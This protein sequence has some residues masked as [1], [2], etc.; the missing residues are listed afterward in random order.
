MIKN[1]I[2]PKDDKMNAQMSVLE[3][4]K[5]F[6]QWFSD[7]K[8]RFS[9]SFVVAVTILVMVSLPKHFPTSVFPI[10]GGVLGTLGSSLVIFSFFVDKSM[11]MQPMPLVF[12]RAVADFFIG[13]RF[14]M[15]PL[16][17]YFICKDFHCTFYE[18]F[19]HE[20]R[21]AFASAWLE[22][23]ELASECWFFCVA[24]DTFFSICD[25]F[26][27]FKRRL[28][29]YHMFSWGLPLIFGLFT[30][31]FTYPSMYTELSPDGDYENTS[32]DAYIPETSRNSVGGF[33]Y[34]RTNHY[35]YNH[36]P[37]VNYNGDTVK[38]HTSYV[39]LNT[40]CWLR[41]YSTPC[42]NNAAN[43]RNHL[44]KYTFIFLYVPLLL[45]YGVAFLLIINTIKTLKRGISA[46]FLPRLR[47]MLINSLN[48]SVGF[49]YWFFLILCYTLTT[50]IA[51]DENIQDKAMASV[52]NKLLQFTI[53]SKGAGAF[54]VWSMMYNMK[55]AL[56]EKIDDS[57]DVN[58][59]L[60]KELLLYTSEGI[61][62]CAKKAAESQQDS[63]LGP[64]SSK[65]STSSKNS[66]S[67]K[68]GL[69]GK[70][71]SG[72]K[73]SNQDRGD[74][75]KICLYISHGVERTKEHN[76]DSNFA[77]EK[78][79]FWFFLK[80][81]LGFTKEINELQ[82]F[83]KR[84]AK[85]QENV[86]DTVRASF[87]LNDPYSAGRGSTGGIGS[88]S[89]KL[90]STV[91]METINEK[92]KNRT[93]SS[94]TKTTDN[95]DGRDSTLS[96]AQILEQSDTRA[97]NIRDT[98]VPTQVSLSSE[99]DTTSRDTQR[100]VIP[101]TRREGN[102][103]VYSDNEDNNRRS[104]LETVKVALDFEDAEPDQNRSC[105]DLL[106]SAVKTGID[107]LTMNTYDQDVEF[108]E[109]LPHE[110]RKI[111]L[112][113]G[114]TD[115]YYQ[116][117]FT[118]TVKERATEGGASGA[119]FF[120]SKDEICVAKAMSEEDFNALLSHAKEYVA[121]MID[122]E[123]SYIAKIYGCYQ[124]NIYRQKFFL[125]VMNNIFLN[126]L[127]HNN[128]DA[129]DIKGSWEARNAE[130]PKK[131]QRVPCKHCEQT[132]VYTKQKKK[133]RVANSL[134]SPGTK[135]WGGFGAT[136]SPFASLARIDTSTSIESLDKNDL[137]SGAEVDSAK[138]DSRDASETSAINPADGRAINDHDYCLFT[139]N[140]D[141]QHEPKVTYKDN[142][143]REKIFLEPEAAEKLLNTLEKDAEFLKSQGV[144]DYSLLM[145]VHRI[146]YDVNIPDIEESMSVRMSMVSNR[147][148]AAS[149]RNE[150]EG[151]GSSMIA[152]KNATYRMPLSVGQVHGPHCYYLGIID[153]QQKFT[154]KKRL[155]TWFKSTIYNRDPD[156]ISSIEPAKY[157]EVRRRAS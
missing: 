120:H 32:C 128:L 134:A 96:P 125:F 57:V 108:V 87:A 119:L 29:Y 8:A 78:L 23:A 27:S 99:T 5:Q 104:M 109:F 19:D 67:G 126:N 121:H 117:I 156:G 98:Y 130:M 7:W 105:Y 36:D 89:H 133:R 48:I 41:I 6:I 25:P 154:Y 39:D 12:W 148:T 66:T 59:A 146:N 10:I 55:H 139:P 107:I 91:A 34:I 18:H 47:V 147:D 79:T 100:S 143:L 101:S 94:D 115:D 11:Q 150:S 90:D 63:I 103:S 137:E 122:N 37:A 44:D 4:L 149:F 76:E 111:R 43:N 24:W 123:D 56:T 46:T 45:I 21:C 75:K 141:R 142:D 93:E 113:A 97:S 3:L 16:F 85:H 58:T 54:I 20:G 60:K 155:E 51:M 118:T 64:T 102:I 152:A 73:Q 61:R 2:V 53:S 153:F 140:A 65:Q 81:S 82:E 26:V 116:H 127:N 1:E 38:S 62:K 17:N 136:F 33:W 132:F 83:G 22:F 72:S 84:T 71:G 88:Q 95:T 49:L 42:A 144:M 129:Y 13:I 50:G 35:D 14:V 68:F 80:V 30:L 138:S 77:E 110:F 112:Q 151:E 145:G 52:F 69:S 9:V 28:R 124:L 40:F 15:N 74:V 86:I 135:T 31:I 70:F 106:P 157:K 114:L 131:N 92:S